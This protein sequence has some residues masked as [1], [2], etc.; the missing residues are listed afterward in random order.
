MF[1]FFK[2]ID[3]VFSVKNIFD[4]EYTPHISRVREVAGGVP[5]VG[6]SFFASMKYNF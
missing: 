5:E 2:K 4:R 3:F 1:N 6:R